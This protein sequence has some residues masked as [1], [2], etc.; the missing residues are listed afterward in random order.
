VAK[1]AARPLVT[2]AR[3]GSNSDMGISVKEWPTHS[4]PPNNIQKKNCSDTGSVPRL[5]YHWLRFWYRWRYL[6]E[7]LWLV[8]ALV[9]KSFF[10]ICS[11]SVMFFSM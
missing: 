2:A 3:V 1:L 11:A 9:Y 6:L 4:S 8:T 7:V 5:R 10:S